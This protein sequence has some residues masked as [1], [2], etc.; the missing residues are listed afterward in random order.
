MVETLLINMLSSFN[1]SKVTL[2]HFGREKKINDCITVEKQFIKCVWFI[3][4]EIE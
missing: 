2:R 4:K 1:S 3:L